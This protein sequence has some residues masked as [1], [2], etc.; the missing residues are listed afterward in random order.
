[1]E[2]PLASTHEHAGDS[3]MCAC[4]WWGA[5]EDAGKVNLKNFAS[6]TTSLLGIEKSYAT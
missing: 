3:R 5:R 4:S 6:D 2:Q 1:M